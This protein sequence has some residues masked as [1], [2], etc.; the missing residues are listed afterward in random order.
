VAGA[1]GGVAGTLGG[2]EFRSRLVRATGEGFTDRPA[3]DTIACVGAVCI[4]TDFRCPALRFLS[5]PPLRE[6]A[7]A[8]LP[9][10]THCAIAATNDSSIAR[11]LVGR[12]FR[13]RHSLDRWASIGPRA[14]AAAAASGA[15]RALGKTR[16]Q[17]SGN[18]TASRRRCATALLIPEAP[19][20]TGPSVHHGRSA[21]NA[22][23]HAEP[24][25]QHR[26]KR[27]VQ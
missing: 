11:R 26:G 17:T 5:A 27:M 16:W 8:S 14:G 24:Q 2:Y 25:D 15:G 6:L 3:R 10:P 23:R 18:A 20:V 12:S 4:V 22:D 21:G 7:N 19:S 1:L 13:R 9:T